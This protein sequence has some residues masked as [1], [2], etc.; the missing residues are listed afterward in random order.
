MEEATGNTR[1]TN[2]VLEKQRQADKV[3]VRQEV[4]SSDRSSEAA[5]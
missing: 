2:E 1:G 4:I 5:C 3:G